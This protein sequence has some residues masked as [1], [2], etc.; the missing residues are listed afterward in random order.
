[1][2]LLR[3]SG[4]SRAGHH[5][6]CCPGF[7]TW[8]R[9]CGEGQR[10]M[11]T[12]LILLRDIVSF[13]QCLIRTLSSWTITLV[14]PLKENPAP[15]WGGFHPNLISL[16]LPQTSFGA[17]HLYSEG[18]SLP[19]SICSFNGL[20]NILLLH[21]SA[22]SMSLTEDQASECTCVVHQGRLHA[23]ASHASSPTR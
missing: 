14:L 7:L 8:E 16:Q 9:G 22:N 13:H 12:G 4:V 15:P 10:C 3:E 17:F 2:G 5:L 6:P 19:F 20:I 1:M 11:V 23:A 18:P 21:L